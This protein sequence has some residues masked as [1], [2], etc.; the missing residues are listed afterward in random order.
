M[1]VTALLLPISALVAVGGWEGLITGLAT[2]K[3]PGYLSWFGARGTGEGWLFVL[4]I[5]GIGLGYPGQPH[6]VNRFMALQDR[7]NAIKHARRIAMT[8]AV[9]VYTGMFVVGL[10]GRV[11]VTQLGDKEVIFIQLANQLFHPVLAGIMLAAVLSAIMSTADSQL[12]VAA[13]SIAHD[14]MAPSSNQT[15]I[16]QAR[17]VVLAV[18]LLATLLAL[19]GSKDIFTSVLFAWSAMGAAFGPLL[20]ITVLRGPVAPLPT[21]LSMITGFSLSVLFYSFSATK[22]GVFERIIPFM[23]AALIALFFPAPPKQTS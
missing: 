20:L 2:V 17:W 19:F 15:Q 13:S 7:P 23:V 4:G 18:S 22:G 12:L 8:W 14:V 3:Q 9:M 5:L 10:C 6:V 16:K 1:A 21:L 11:L